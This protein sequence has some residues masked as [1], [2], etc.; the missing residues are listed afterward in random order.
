MSR[1]ADFAVISAR[2]VLRKRARL[3]LT[4]LGIAIGVAAVIGIVSLGEG[5]RYQ[6]VEMIKDQSDLTFIEITGN[7]RGGTI[8][9]LTDSKLSAISSVPGI[10]YSEPVLKGSFASERQT[11][12]SVTG[13]DTGGFKELFSPEFQS[14][15]IYKENS[16]EV[17]LGSDIAEKLRRY[18]GIRYGDTF[19]V[20]IRGYDESGMPDDQKK[21]LT[22]AGI[23]R[24]RG[25]DIDN[26]VIM[27]RNTIHEIIE[28]GDYYDS[29]YA[30]TV[31]PED[32]FPVADS[33]KEMGL[34]VTGSFEEIESVNRLMDTVIIVLSFFTGISLIIGALMII[35]TMVISVFERTRE[36]GITMA[37]GA[38]HR[39]VISLI[40]LECLYIGIIGG[41]IGDI[42]GIILS[43]GINTI[44]KPFVISQMGEGFSGFAET[45]ITLI[46][47]E[48][49]AAGII[50]AVFLAIA[51]GI[52]PA[53]KASRLNPVEAI[54]AGR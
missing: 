15:E 18:E 22:V 35:N 4:A 41:I 38:S 34:G 10:S 20:L 8:I 24:E 6:S 12:L 7:M 5:I 1:I 16:Y 29:V 47:P 28:S 31:S 44:G 11:Y 42:A 33:I 25:D 53:I 23:L 26:L 32:V 36:I 50:I 30:R 49:L 19:T 14:G 2:Q 52:Y 21:E 51:S 27:D 39:D 13:I 43:A 40:L 9:P 45:D 46:T 48:L 3:F 37:I 17:I 54:R